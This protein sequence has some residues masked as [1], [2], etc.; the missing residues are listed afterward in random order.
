MLEMRITANVWKDTS[1]QMLEVIHRFKWWK[2]YTAANVG[3]YTYP[4]ICWNDTHP[5]KCWKCALLQ[6]FEKIHHSAIVE[7]GYIFM[8]FFVL[9]VF[10]TSSK[11]IQVA[12]SVLSLL[13][14]TSA[15]C[16]RRWLLTSQGRMSRSARSSRNRKEVYLI[17]SPKVWLLPF[18][19]MSLWKRWELQRFFSV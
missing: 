3:N 19:A 17:F 7:N 12:P 13:P 6:M 1:L 10:R 8:F 14:T 4:C 2:W 9:G 11:A 18:M 15:S 16:L 5:C